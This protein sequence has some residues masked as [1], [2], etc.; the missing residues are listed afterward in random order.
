MRFIILF[1]SAFPKPGSL[2]L[3]GPLS[4]N[5]TGRVE[6][7]YDRQWGTI[8]DDEWDLQDAKVACRQLGFLD[9]ISAL[10]GSQVPSGSGLILLDGVSCTGKERNLTSC[11]HRGWRIHDCS[12][13]EDAGVQ[14]STTGK[15]NVLLYFIL[16][17]SILAQFIPFDLKTGFCYRQSFD[18][19]SLDSLLATKVL[20]PDICGAHWVSYVYVLGLDTGEF[21]NCSFGW[22]FNPK[23]NN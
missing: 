14:C 2:R 19:P 17:R 5:G 11:S 10:Q 6:V 1:P 8:C 7:F 4:A 23:N 9:A 15:F 16:Q 3:R 12:H 22:K 21:N 18:R 20:T 13:S